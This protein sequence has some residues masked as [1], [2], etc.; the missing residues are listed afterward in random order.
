M[1]KISILIIFLWLVTY[2]SFSS[3]PRFKHLTSKDGISQSEVYCF[4][5]DQQ[6][7]IWFGTVDG[8][9]KYDGY[10]ITRF[11]T[12]KNNINTLSNNTIRALTEDSKNRIWI[13][14][15]DGL[16]VYD[17]RSETIFQIS[18]DLQQNDLLRIT[19]L[20]IDGDNLLLGTSLGLL[21]TNIGSDNLT[22]IEKGFKQLKLVGLTDNPTNEIK[23]IIPSKQGGYWLLTFYDV[24]RFSVP[25]TGTDAIFI[26]KLN[27]AGYEGYS[28]LVEDNNLNIWLATENMGLVRY[29]SQNGHFDSF[30]NS[31]N[32]NSITSNRCSELELD[33]DGNLWIGTIDSG[34]N[35]ILS[36]DLDRPKTDV[37]FLS[38]KYNNFNPN[39]LNSNLIY[40]LY[41]TRDNLLWIG[42]IGSGVNIYDP[43]QKDFSHYKLRQLTNDL[44]HSNFIRSL[45]VDSSDKFWVGTHN[46]GLFLFD[47]DQESISKMGFDTRSIFFIS[48]Y[49]E[50]KLLICSG[51]GLDLIEHIPDGINVLD[52]IRSR[53]TFNIVHTG[54]NNYWLASLDGVKHLKIENDKISVLNEYSVSSSPKMSFN[55]SRVLFYDKNRSELL[56]GT[57]GGGLNIMVLDQNQQAEKIFVYKKD[58]NPTSLSSN[59]I[60][61]ILQDS[62]GDI[63]IGTYEGVNKLIR[64]DETGDITFRSYTQNDGLPN[65][66]IE[67]IAEDDD[68]NLWLGTNGGLFKTDLAWENFSVYTESDGLQ[69]NEF[70]EN[71]V[72]KKNDGEL[73]FGG[74]NGI[75]AFY[76]QN[77]VP[78]SKNPNIAITSFYLFQKKVNLLEAFKGN[79][80]LEKSISL[81]DSIFLL[82]S[83]NSI[84]FD[85]S[86]LIFNNP[87]KIE[88]KYKLEG[89]E[90]EWNKTTA[91]NRHAN[92]TNLRHGIYLFKVIAT[93]E[94]GVF[95]ET[96]TEVF[97][98]IATPVYL[99]WYAYLFYI[100]L[101]L[102]VMLFFRFFSVIQYKTKHKLILENEHNKKLRGLDELRAKFFINI[103]HDLRTP[104][105][106]IREPIRSILK[107]HDLNA[108]QR[109]KLMLAER[110]AQHLNNLVEQLLD[111]RKAESGKI[112]PHYKTG[113]IVAFSKNILENFD[114]MLEKKNIHAHVQS[115]EKQIITSFDHGILSKIY[116]NLISNAINYTNQGTITIF[117]EKIDKKQ[118]PLISKSEHED[119]IRI[120]I[121]D[122]GRG[123]SK[124]NQ[125]KIFERFYQDEAAIEKGYGI[126][127]SHTRDLVTAHSGFIDVESEPGVGT[128][129]T[130]ILPDQKPS[131]KTPSV[132]T[133]QLPNVP[134]PKTTLSA[135]DEDHILELENDERRILIVED[136][137]ELR[138]YIKSE[139]SHEYEVL[140][141]ADGLEGVKKANEFLP[142]LIISDVMM[143]EM[144]GVELCK[145]LKTNIKTSHIPII[146]LTA[147][148][149][150]NTKYQGIET[151]ADDFIPKPFELEYLVIRI[152]NLLKSRDKLRELFRKNFDINPSSVSVTSLDEKFIKEMLEAIEKGISNSEFT[153]N[154][155]E[156]ELGM[157]HANFYRK[158]KSLTGQSGKEILQEMRLKRALQIL[159]DN[160]EVRI[161]DVAYMVGFSN[162]KYFSK[163]FKERFG[164]IP[165]DVK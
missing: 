33:N 45:Y 131:E 11:N 85:F 158:V 81:K 74:I 44:S 99:T 39:A 28:S 154:T 98:Q 3:E 116:S 108:T 134:S 132:V 40:S 13:G 54:G 53:A 121:K 31:E 117:I 115:A 78:S 60:R 112:I 79:V 48:P 94:D 2:S 86:A 6:G 52:S 120:A 155:L 22:D 23:S 87:Y 149:D 124:E 55:N 68:G 84:G 113:D 88:Y 91:Q 163:C 61:S 50:N 140:E 130:V 17:T 37:S 122:T 56:V 63:W 125:S 14:T 69:S 126:G 92:Y 110:N 114:Y 59:Y 8:L 157:S 100:L 95:D 1:S 150:T 139:L 25:I 127:L 29:R 62:A 102:S 152:H 16:N 20:L 57:E 89:F 109:R 75:N 162:P 82:P 96:G 76:P 161:S 34:L 138:E 65:N 47:R 7:F 141:A 38:F 42:T 146:L 128:T 165:S 145:E 83:Q 43:E 119:F 104:L 18:I 70:S 148:V 93:N 135:D 137:D 153:V 156:A 64:D 151:G 58:K 111:V 103:S 36:A 118:N 133:E 107:S 19:S 105:T 129:M 26:E 80:I 97:I 143:P 41:S 159:N 142:D 71:A 46:S 73:V 35:M 147:K 66:M 32:R 12:E 77:I 51:H 27:I 123:I 30:R 21:I 4:L 5:Q 144:D 49:I 15:D 90:N 9:N 72:F 101:I 136:N 24:I 106:L 10:E 160:P 164:Y 67:S